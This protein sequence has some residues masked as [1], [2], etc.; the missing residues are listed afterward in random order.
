MLFAVYWK[1]G[2]WVDNLTTIDSNNFWNTF[3]LNKISNTSSITF[4]ML[5]RT[6]LPPVAYVLHLNYEIN[7]LIFIDICT[8]H[9]YIQYIYDSSWH[10]TVYRTIAEISWARVKSFC[11]ISRMET[12]SVLETGWTFPLKTYEIYYRY[13]MIS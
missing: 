9:V 13:G 6:T 4:L 5:K 3:C 11:A 7:W 10:S 12:G 1:G 2:Y 8:V